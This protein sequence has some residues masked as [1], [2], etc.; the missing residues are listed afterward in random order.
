M[1]ANKHANVNIKG[2]IYGTALSAIISCGH[3]ELFTLLVENGADVNSRGGYS[4]STALVAANN[5]SRDE[6]AKIL[7]ENGT[8]VNA[9]TMSYGTA[10]YSAS[11]RGHFELATLL[12]EQGAHVNAVGDLILVRHSRQHLNRVILRSSSCC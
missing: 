6:L 7:L 12:L 1:L 5:Y 3:P 2:E 4:V 9:D 10:L 8:H 11:M